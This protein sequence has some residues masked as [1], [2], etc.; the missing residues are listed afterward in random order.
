MKQARFV[1]ICRKGH[2]WLDAPKIEAKFSLR[3][4]CTVSFMDD[5]RI[6]VENELNVEGRERSRRS[7][8][9]TLRRISL[10]CLGAAGEF[11]M[12]TARNY[13]VDRQRS[14]SALGGQTS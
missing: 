5:V 12:N 13:I 1:V 6:P 9:C 11:C 3:A 8:Q 10:G 2:T 4:S 7:E 14:L